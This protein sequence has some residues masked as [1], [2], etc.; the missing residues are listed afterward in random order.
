MGRVLGRCN[1]SHLVFSAFRQY[2]VNLAKDDGA[3]NEVAETCS[4]DDSN[5]DEDVK[6]HDEKHEQVAS[7]HLQHMHHAGQQTL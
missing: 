2:L 1:I 4:D 3:N 7:G 5:D 6:G